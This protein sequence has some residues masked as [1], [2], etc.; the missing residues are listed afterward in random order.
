M[1]VL[2]SPDKSGSW[3][4]L[5]R[6]GVGC[7]CCLWSSSMPSDQ[8]A[9]GYQRRWISLVFVG[10]VPTCHH[11]VAELPWSTSE[12]HLAPEGGGLIGASGVLPPARRSLTRRPGKTHE[13]SYTA[14]M[15]AR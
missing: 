15:S 11:F 10:W 14:R 9:R 1:S 6:Q 2:G 4:G 13:K 5:T 8:E 3:Y 7:L 12:G